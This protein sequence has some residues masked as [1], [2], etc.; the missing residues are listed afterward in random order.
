MKIKKGD[1]VKILLGKDR[2]KEGKV[3]FVLGKSKK[4]FV[5]GVN[6]YK[7]SLRADA[8]KRHGETKGRIIDIPKPL[9]ISN[10]ALICPNCNKLTRVGF[11]TDGGAKVRICKRCGKEINSNAKA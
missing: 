8:L 4:L 5:G 7:R 10:V 1:K 11:K 9:D 3:E 6:L 2:G